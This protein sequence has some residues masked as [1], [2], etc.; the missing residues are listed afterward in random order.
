MARERIRRF[1]RCRVLTDPAAM[2]ADKRLLLDRELHS[3]ANAFTGRLAAQRQRFAACAAKLDALSPM[4]VLGRGYAIPQK[5]GRVVTSAK[6][7]KPQDEFTLK[8]QDGDVSCQV[9]KG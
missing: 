1:E 8:L 9:L 3:L 7:L 6:E 4:K 5:A 2:V